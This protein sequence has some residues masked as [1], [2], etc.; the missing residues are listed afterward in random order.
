[1]RKG[2]ETIQKTANR[3]LS[4]ARET[5]NWGNGS[6]PSARPSV[7]PDSQTACE[8]CGGFGFYRLDVPF[9]DSRFG[10]L[11]R[12]PC[13]AREDAERLQKLS[14]LTEAERAVRL[15]GIITEGRPQTRAMLAACAE[16]LDHPYGTLVIHGT[17]GN[18]KTLALQGCVNALLD[19]CVEAVYVT[20]F[21]LISYIR[22]AFN[23]KQEI[24]SGSAYDR[25]VRFG[26][27]RF[28]A[29]D[30]FDKIKMSEWVV[31]QVTDLI[32]RRYRLGGDEQVGTMIAMNE[33]PR[34]LPIWIYSRLSQGTIIRNDDSDLRPYLKR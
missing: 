30:E 24:K 22:E 6:L 5:L 15:S 21:D 33:D 2:M 9:T 11:F 23:E 16:F 27:V 17:S 32:D 4:K 34:N 26:T 13:K 7:Q 28:L 20:A 29:I 31:E 14:G 18:A 12:C 8:I 19:V 1:M 3:T 10:K 25:I